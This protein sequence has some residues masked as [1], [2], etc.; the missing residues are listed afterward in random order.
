MGLVPGY[1]ITVATI[2]RMG[3]KTIQYMG[4][5][6]MTI[7]LVI[8]SAAWVPLRAQ[9]IWAFIVLYALTFLFANWGPNR[10]VRRAG[11]GWVGG[12]GGP[13]R[14]VARAL[15]GAAARP[16]R[17][18]VRRRGRQ[19]ARGPRR[20][21]AGPGGRAFRPSP[22][23]RLAP[24]A[25]R[26]AP[27]PPSPHPPPIPPAPLP[28]PHPSNPPAPPSLSPASV[29]RRNSAALATASRRP[30][31]RRAPSWASTALAR[32]TTSTAPR[33]AWGSCRSSCSWVSGV[34]GVVAFGG[35]GA[36]PWG[37]GLRNSST[38]ARRPPR[39]A[40]LERQRS[41][42]PTHPSTPHRHLPPPRPAVHLLHPRDHWHVPG[43]HQRRGRPP[44][45]QGR[46]RA[47]HQGGRGVE[48]GR[49]APCLGR[50]SCASRPGAAARCCGR[51]GAP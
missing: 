21:R 6:I 35:W 38:A 10:C 17:C 11:G 49:A 31:A 44:P 29:S 43:D 40:S 28:T 24:A 12:T 51:G 18:G 7:L 33:S 9:A 34:V 25:A 41:P 19:R 15:R 32:S 8:C 22:A 4:F 2:E 1:F 48:G 20:P 37:S 5:I 30:G 26:S 36:G 42:P 50:R 39:S 47:A 45:R 46:R 23:A 14:A 16:A 3:R 13:A 27:A